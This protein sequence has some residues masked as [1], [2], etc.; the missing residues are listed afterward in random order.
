[1]HASIF[2]TLR[3]AL[4]RA[5]SSLAVSPVAL[6]RRNPALCLIC[7]TSAGW[8]FS[9][10]L[11]APLI[12]IWLDRAGCSK[13]VIGWNT[14]IYYL[15]MALAAAIVPWMM[16]RLGTLCPVLG[17]LLAGVTVASF[18]WGDGLAW[19]FGV[20][21]L[22][23]VAG[24]LCVIPLET[25]VNRD[26]AEGE[27]ARNFG[28]YA[29]A[30]T[31]G[32][33]LGNGVGLHLAVD[34]PRLAFVLGGA[35][36]IVSGLAVW[37]GLPHQ[38]LMPAERG[39]RPQL[40]LRRNFL[41]YASAWNQGFL[42]GGMVAFLALYLLSLHLSEQSVGL[43]TSA[44]M[45]GVIV[46]QIPVAWLA[47][48]CGRTAVLISCYAVVAAAL[49]FLPLCE[50][51]AWLV[52]WLFLVGACSGAFYPLGLALLGERVPQANLARA[53][54]VYLAVE[55][56]G[57]WVGPSVMG[58][59][60]DSH[61]DLRAMFATALAVLLSSLIIWFGLQLLARRQSLSC[62]AADST[63]DHGRQAA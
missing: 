9:F 30:I 36:A 57:C 37:R 27:R 32:W 13:G 58:A 16:R 15:G 35:V 47:D 41:S 12:S 39:A 52:V 22:N 3:Q 46:F 51:S 43:L 25:Y 29:V 1:M 11:S 7:L 5:V 10:G 23:G 61:G 28:C 14:G 33:A 48:R 53:N 34:W 4:T 54:A 50:P 56:V 26:A 31:L 44:T 19:W 21:F 49:V 2:S 60:I 24:A 18:P 42:E 17:M 63:N 62:G 6:F 20:R 59:V 40:E 55:C 45:V 8:A 38:N